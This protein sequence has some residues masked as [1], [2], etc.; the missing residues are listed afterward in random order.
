MPGQRDEF[1][2]DP[3]FCL[4]LNGIAMFPAVL[5]NLPRL[6]LLGLRA[7]VMNRLHLSVDGDALN[8]TLA[9]A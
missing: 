8:V 4:E 9:T 3:P 6:P 2:A 5:G 1:A 7:L